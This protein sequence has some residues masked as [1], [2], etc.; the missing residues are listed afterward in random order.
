MVNGE[1]TE[2]LEDIY[3]YVYTC[4]TCGLKYGSDKKETGK[5]ICPLCEKKE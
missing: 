4:D 2:G 5:F 3:K 1:R